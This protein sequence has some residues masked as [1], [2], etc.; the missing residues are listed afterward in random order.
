MHENMKYKINPEQIINTGF[1]ITKSSFDKTR[2]LILEMLSIT[3]TK[4]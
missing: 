2:L 3:K 1:L 4:E